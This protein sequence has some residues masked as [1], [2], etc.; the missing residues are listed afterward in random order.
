MNAKYTFPVQSGDSTFRIYHDYFVINRRGA[1]RS[2]SNLYPSL[3]Y[4]SVLYILGAGEL[5]GVDITYILP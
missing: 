1:T 4:A 2:R 5:P 3:V